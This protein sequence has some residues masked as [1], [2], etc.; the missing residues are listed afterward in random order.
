MAVSNVP[1]D[2]STTA[3]TSTQPSYLQSPTYQTLPPS[4]KDSLTKSLSTDELNARFPV[5][6]GQIPE[7]A[8]PDKKVISLRDY[9][10]S[11]RNALLS[12]SKA[13]EESEKS[14]LEI[15]RANSEAF[16]IR[17]ASLTSLITE[18]DLALKNLDKTTKEIEEELKKLLETIEE[19]TKAQ[20]DLID[21]LNKGNAEEKKQYDELAKAYDEYINDLKKMGA[22]DKG[23]GEFEIPPGDEAQ[24]KFNEITQKYQGKVDNFNK[25]WAVRHKQLVDY[26]AATAAYNENVKKNNQALDDLLASHGLTNFRESQDI[27]YQQKAEMR[28]LSKH[29]AKID[30]PKTIGTNPTKVDTKPPTRTAP[31]S[32]ASFTKYPSMKNKDF[33]TPLRDQF[34][35]SQIRPLDNNISVLMDLLNLL[36]IRQIYFEDDSRSP[37][38][39]TKSL[40]ERLLPESEV[41]L[42]DPNNGQMLS[43]VYS[44]MEIDNP[45][46]A[47]LL[48]SE[49]LKQLLAQFDREISE[50]EIK[51]LSDKLLM[52]SVSQLNNNSV[53]ALLPGLSLI[54]SSLLTLPQDSP[55]LALLFSISFVNRVQE[56]SQLGITQE[57][58]EAF[59]SKIPMLAKL[60]PEQKK[61]LASTL[62]VGAMLAASKLLEANLGLPGLMAQILPQLITDNPAP[63]LLEAAAENRQNREALAKQVEETY[64]A[65]GYSLETAQFLAK[66]STELMDEG[67]SAPTVASVP[68]AESINAP[69]LTDSI[70]ASLLIAKGPTFPLAEAREIA[71]ESVSLALADAPYYTTNQFRNA[72]ESNLRDFGLKDGIEKIVRDAVILLPQETTLALPTEESITPAL[73]HAELMQLIQSRVNQLII[74]QLGTKLA[75]QVTEEIAKSLFGTT[76]PEAA[77]LTEVTSPFSLVG[78]LRNELYHRTAK[79][80]AEFAVSSHEDFKKTIEESTTNLNAFLLKLQ[81]PLAVYTQIGLMYERNDGKQKKERSV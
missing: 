29:P 30:G 75:K 14:E 48:G 69:L 65:K 17:A 57:S 79:D 25:Y 80:E 61:K 49:H 32:L 67:L 72:L 13:L 31:P 60:S 66:V 23:N 12:A 78:V 42:I 51:N 41:S 58:L 46:I 39:N 76:P 74:P 4:E 35:Q 11:R 19:Q 38:L 8:A 37:S 50:T 24:K 40:M 9:L 36:R 64:T 34:Y 16:A 3:P 28:D 73:S 20:K 27:P 62:N 55:A 71:S 59:S 5:G 1:G 10:A 70:Q 21:E 2:R 15:R 33:A 54:F 63:L 45:D 26:N 81:D 47:K 44:T 68:S 77:A 18:R 22:I 52:F 6:V 53:Q 43:S 56:M 7:L